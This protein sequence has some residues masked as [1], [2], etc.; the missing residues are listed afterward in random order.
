MAPSEAVEIIAMIGLLF[1]AWML[2]FVMMIRRTLDHAL[3]L[4]VPWTVTLSC[5]LLVAEKYG[6]VWG[7]AVLAVVIVALAT[8]ASGA[9]GTREDDD[10]NEAS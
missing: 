2:V 4:S 9:R 1:G 3:R 10:D 7:A 6:K 8:E 5:A